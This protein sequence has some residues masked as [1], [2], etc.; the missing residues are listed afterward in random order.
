[1]GRGCD[2][3]LDSTVNEGIA[4]DDFGNE[5]LHA[6]AVFGDGFHQ[7]IHHD[8]V[9]AFKLAAQGIGQKFLRQ[10]PGKI[11]RSRGDE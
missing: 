1:M 9:I 11:G 7:A 5:S 3:F 10:R 6:I 8:F 2:L 4:G